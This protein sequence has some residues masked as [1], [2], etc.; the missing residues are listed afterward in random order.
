MKKDEQTT[1]NH[2][3]EKLLKLKDMMKTQVLGSSLNQSTILHIC[4]S[5][6]LAPFFPSIPKQVLVIALG[7]T[8]QG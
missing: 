1:V 2:F 6:L 8:Q 3:H 7:W 5:L 4:P